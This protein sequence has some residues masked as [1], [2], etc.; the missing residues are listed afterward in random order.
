MENPYEILNLSTGASIDDVKRAYYYILKIYQPNN[1][2]NP[3]AFAKFQRAYQQIMNSRTQIQQNTP[4][5]QNI[6]PQYTPIIMDH[7]YKLGD[8]KNNADFNS[9]FKSQKVDPESDGY[10][11]NI[12]ESAYQERNKGEYERTHAQITAEAESVTRMFANKRFDPNVFN[13]MFIQMKQ[14]HTEMNGGEQIINE[15]QPVSGTAIIPYSDIN[16]IRD[17][18]NITSLPYTDYN[19]VYSTTHKNPSKYDPDFL[20]KLA[21]KKDIT[22]EL[23]IEQGY[24][25]NMQKRINSYKQTELKY[26]TDPLFTDNGQLFPNTKRHDQDQFD[27]HK[28]LMELRA[29][30]DQLRTIPIMS[31][32]ENSNSR[33]NP[34]RE[35]H[36]Y[37]PEVNMPPTTNSADFL[38]QN[39]YIQQIKQQNVERK[40]LFS[41]AVHKQ[42]SSRHRH[43]R[44][45]RDTAP[46]QQHLSNNNMHQ[47]KETIELQQKLISKLLTKRS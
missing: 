35:L 2:G 11:Y 46:Q 27:M 43:S 3:Q 18:S 6:N 4:N 19:T 45:H 1:G 23:P 44:H 32:P 17:S 29:Q 28:K 39:Q 8:F 36:N 22:K 12:D 25:G 21:H 20:K 31:Y 30:P 9:A 34:N 16:R 37:V 10:V 42:K 47:M 41:R 14:Q 33:D 26:N 15:P 5:Q 38:P 7:R 40:N 24:H 13:R